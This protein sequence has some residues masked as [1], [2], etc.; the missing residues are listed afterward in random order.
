MRIA[1]RDRS[2]LETSLNANMVETGALVKSSRQS[3]CEDSDTVR[4][5]KNTA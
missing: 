5:V 4:R 3:G 1:V 2:K